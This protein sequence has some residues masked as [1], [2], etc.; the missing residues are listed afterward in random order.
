MRKIK[1]AQ[2]GINRYS[3]GPE[4]FYTMKKNPEIFD[5]V[6]YVL[7]EDERQTCAGK[8]EQFYGGYPELSLQQVLDDPSIEAVTIE[9]DEIHLLKYAQ[10]AVE[11]GKH[12]H[13]EKPGSPSLADFDRLI[14]T[15][16][17]KKTVFHIGYMFRYN[18]I[19][20][21]TIRRVRGGELGQIYSVEALMGRYD[22]RACREWLGDFPGGQ[23]FYLGSNLID[24]VMQMQG[25][26]KCVIPLNISTGL[27][28]VTSEDFGFAVLRYDGATSVVRTCACEVGGNT[29]RQIVV[30]GEKGTIE[31]RPIE[32][33]HDPTSWRPIFVA[34]SEAAI[35]DADGHTV[36]EHKISEPFGR[37]QDMICSFAAMVRG[38]MENPYTLDYERSLFCTIMKCCGAVQ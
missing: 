28:G 33:P 5:L 19:V 22:D 30:C 24:V 12:V 6:G 10:M 9:T 29:R 11:H 14:E 34:E 17:Q 2:I 25:E 36:R 23:M 8:I 26:P 21:D 38:E 7:V 1:I 15:V 32:A 13:M 37:Y 4:L 35:L 16:R 20:A 27:G 31:I 3:H 18:P